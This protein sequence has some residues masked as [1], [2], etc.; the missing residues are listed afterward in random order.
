VN[1]DSA[2]YAVNNAFAQYYNHYHCARI[3]IYS[4]A[5]NEM[6]T[7]FFGGIAQYYDSAG[8][9]IQDNNVPFVK[10]IARVTR[11]A[12]GVM[13]EYKLPLDMPALLGAGSEFI[14]PEDLPQ[15]A[16]EVIKLDDLN[17]DSTLL[18]YIYGG[19]SSSAP[20]VFFI[21]T[22]TQSTASSQIF[23]VYAV[24]A[25]GSDLHALNAQSR[26]T[27]H[28]QVYPNPNDGHFLVLFNLNTAADVSISISDVTG[29]TILSTVLTQRPAGENSYSSFE[30]GL[31][32]G[33]TYFIT[34]SANGETVTQKI[35]IAAE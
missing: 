35:I 4:S 20:N 5:T 17:D 16:N 27:L 9:L 26:G 23:K 24:K 15:Y 21:N 3:P 18:G 2:G 25:N 14:P 34:L 1:I 32:N 31:R 10:T 13:S 8:T 19:I 30:E 11:N 12:A 7:V 6:H 33:G 28:L 29:K 22:G